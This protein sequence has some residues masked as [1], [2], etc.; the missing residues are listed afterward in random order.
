[1]QAPMRAGSPGDKHCWEP[2]RVQ[3]AGSGRCGG[4]PGGVGYPE[5][6]E[7]ELACTGDRWVMIDLP[8]PVKARP[9]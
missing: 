7:V 3:S 1:M 5:C 6:W 8:W 9:A 2:V 4:D